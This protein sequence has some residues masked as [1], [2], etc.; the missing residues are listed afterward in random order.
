[1]S[2]P[3]KASA[4]IIATKK[5]EIIKTKITVNCQQDI[6][7]SRHSCQPDNYV[8]DEIELQNIN[9]GDDRASDEDDPFYHG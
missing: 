3:T 5:L 6:T 8:E 2:T 9:C 7:V 1:M 4:M